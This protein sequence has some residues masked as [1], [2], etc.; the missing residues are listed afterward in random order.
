MTTIRQITFHNFKRFD[1]FTLNCRESNILVGPNNAGKSSILDALRVLYGAMR[2]AKRLKPRLIRTTAG[3]DWGY[4]IPDS[5]ILIG[6][7]NVVRNY[8]D[9]DAIIEFTHSNGRKLIVELHPDHLTRL[10]IRDA[11]KHTS[12]GKSYFSL[13][14]VTVVIVPTLSP[15]EQEELY[16]TDD[17]VDRN[18][19]NRLA[20]RYF[21]NIWYRSSKEEFE[22]FSNLIE[23]TWPGI[24]IKRPNRPP[25][26]PKSLEMFYSERRIDREISWAGFGFQVW[27]QILTHAQRGDEDAIFVLDEPDIYLH[28]DLQFQLLQLI[29]NSFKQ[30]FIATHSSEIINRSS[31]G[32]IASINSNYRTSKRIKSDEDYNE[33]F[34]YIGSIENV[35]LSRLSRAKRVIFFEGKDKSILGKF[36]QKANLSGLLEDKE[37]II[38]G[39]GGFGQWRKVLE[40]AWTFKNI[41]Q[42]EV[43]ILS[44]F[45]RDYRDLREINDLITEIS[46]AEVSCSVWNRKEIENYALNSTVLQDT[47]IRRVRERNPKSTLSA[48]GA[49]EIISIVSEEYRHDVISQIVSNATTYERRIATGRDVSQITKEC[50]KE[51]ERNWSSIEDRLKIIP[52]KQFIADL[53]RHL[54]D[55]YSC[56]ITINMMIDDLKISDLDPQLLSVLN[57]VEEFCR[58]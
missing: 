45:D 51:F 40:T 21:R 23:N 7:A 32:D 43:S 28:P 3:E 35:E 39:V 38:I 12:S 37:T 31:P 42:I 53:S 33:V 2:Y 57:Q 48:T 11:N 55:N 58:R 44:L 1:R 29:K 8:G 27:L 49:L 34:A 9:D 24:S 46:S 6:V 22:D 20:S 36:C 47:I 5:S 4:E 10:Y 13:F 54:Q 14:P 30:F 17:T 15:F 56:T 52:G 19:A 41:L 26:S 50:L 16:V 25:E 18:R